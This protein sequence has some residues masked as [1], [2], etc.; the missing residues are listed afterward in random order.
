[1]CLFRSNMKNIFLF[2]PDSF[3]QKPYQ[4]VKGEYFM[5]LKIILLIIIVLAISFSSQAQNGS[6]KLIQQINDKNWNE[7]SWTKKRE[8]LLSVIKT[9]TPTKPQE[10]LQ[11]ANN[12]YSMAVHEKDSRTEV[13]AL[14]YI[15]TCYYYS[16]KYLF[17][18]LNYSKSQ[19]RA[20]EI[21]YRTAEA[22][23]MSNL[24]LTYYVTDKYDKSLLC[25]NNALHIDSL[26]NNQ[27]A[28]A[29]C[30]NGIGTIYGKIQK[31]AQAIDNLNKAKRLGLKLRDSLTVAQS[32]HNLGEVFK[33]MENYDNS[34]LYFDSSLQ[35]QKCKENT[36]N[37][38]QTCYALGEIYEITSK[39][40]K[41]LTFYNEVFERSSKLNYKKGKAMA[42]NGLANILKNQKQYNR[43]LERYLLSLQIMEETGDKTGIAIASDNIGNVFEQTNH[44]DQALHYYNKALEIKQSINNQ[45]GMSTT[46]EYIGM[47][48]FKK[49]EYLKA[50]EYL[51]NAYKQRS[52]SNQ[53][54]ELAYT[55]KNL[56]IT[57]SQI[58]N[59]ELAEE[60]TNQCIAL[61]KKFRIV[62]IEKSGYGLLANIYAQKG[63]FK[64]ALEFDRIH[65]LLKDSIFSM[66]SQKLL[67]DINTK[68]ETNK[69]EN[70]NTIL[71]QEVALKKETILR[72]NIMAFAISTFL[73]LSVIIAIIFFRG[74]QK[75]KHANQLLSQQKQ[76][77]ERQAK[78]LM[79]QNQKLID[80]D[81]FKE[82]MT[83]M[84]VHD[85]KNPLS[86]ILSN[87][88]NADVVQAGNQMLNMVLNILDV[89]KFENAQM[90]L[91]I[92]VNQ[93]NKIL[94][95][96]VAQVKFLLE[97][98]SILFTNEIANSKIVFADF[99]IVSRIFVNLLTNAIKYTP[100]NGRISVSTSYTDIY[101]NDLS[102]GFIKIVVTDSG[103][104]IPSESVSTIFDK[105]TQV[106]ARNSGGVRSTGLGLSFC[107]M[108][109]EAHGG[110]I[111]VV[112]QKNAGSSFWFTLRLGT[113]DIA[114]N[115]DDNTIAEILTVEK[116][117]QLND[118]ERNYL[119]Q[120]IP[121]LS[122][123]AVYEYSSVKNILEKIEVSEN[124]GVAQW[125]NAIVNSLKSCNEEKYNELINL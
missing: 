5:F 33:A 116:T 30:L 24:A 92:S 7:L 99:E 48:F 44:L 69:K 86:T 120:F 63:D 10:A 117:I 56:G 32:L 25:F 95:H 76:M 38:I 17:A 1:M 104:G 112:S 93:L 12:L 50:L 88:Q 41:A 59:Y 54:K 34:R 106:E 27:T 87:T 37:Y 98:K 8:I 2:L 47:I 45:S 66:E 121:E 64:K 78:Q 62:Q 89:Q 26:E 74:R 113:S 21:G 115:Q 80:L 57:Y 114:E 15:G 53:E 81:H 42:H 77:I 40:E 60:Y 19:Q 36:T 103:Q 67:D 58:K 20:K 105:F 70:E 35:L 46:M 43:A 82:G 29:N 13:D 71:R 109:V 14:K 123:C 96:A 110:T 73:L 23:A 11:Y 75:E 111:G 3:P 94:S 4:V 119:L 39:Y 102:L 79:V 122:Q 28:I 16:S 118:L 68:Y 107:K 125:L 51:K 124:K 101:K 55:A 91:Q 61:S 108:A 65:N 97:K 84:I 90:K 22:D 31:F 72:Q 83:G 18:M 9:L 52:E 85:L 100:N 49:N 6:E